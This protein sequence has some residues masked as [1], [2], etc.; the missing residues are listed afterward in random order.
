MNTDCYRNLFELAVEARAKGQEACLVVDALSIRQLEGR[1]RDGEDP[2]LTLIAVT[3]ALSQRNLESIT[4][5]RNIRSSRP[6]ARRLVREEIVEWLCQGNP[7]TKPHRDY[8][9]IRESELYTAGLPL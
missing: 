4:G 9:L 6:H 8:L 5:N 3:D 1:V 2:E 7:A